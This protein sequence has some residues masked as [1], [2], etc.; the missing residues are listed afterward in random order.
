M[1]STLRNVARGGLVATGL[2][3]GAVFVTAAVAAL[4]APLIVAVAWAVGF[5]SFQAT[6]IVMLLWLCVGA[7]L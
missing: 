7:A 1:T 2:L 6:I 5:A 3:A 4:I